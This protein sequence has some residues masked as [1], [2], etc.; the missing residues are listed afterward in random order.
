MMPMSPSGSLRSPEPPK[1][2][3]VLHFEFRLEFVE[4]RIADAAEKYGWCDKQNQILTI[5][6]GQRPRLMADT[7]FH[8]L[9]HAIHFA[10]G[11]EDSLTEEQ[12]CRQFSGPL[13]SVLRD[14][15][16]L[17][18]WLNYLCSVNEKIS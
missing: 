16:Q 14:N 13:V 6:T 15:P 11:C 10:V 8:E 17:F 7:V 2:I 3:R 1:N 4:Q 5:A 18:F 12:I 9:F